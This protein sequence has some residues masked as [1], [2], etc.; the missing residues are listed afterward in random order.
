M[1]KPR[2]TIILLASVILALAVVLIVFRKRESEYQGRSLSEWLTDFEGNTPEVRSSAKFLAAADAIRHIGTSALPYLIE[3]LRYNPDSKTQQALASG[4]DRLPQS[5][6]PSNLDDW[7]SGQTGL[8]NAERAVIAIQILG[9]NALPALPELV[10]IAQD[11]ASEDRAYRVVRALDNIGPQGI[12]ALCQIVSNTN[13][14]SP[15]RHTAALTIGFFGTNSFEAVP[16]L[17]RCLDDP[18]EDVSVGATHALGQIRSVSPASVPAL[19]R[20]L[21]DPSPRK[22]GTAAQSLAHYGPEATPAIPALRQALTNTNL[23][24]QNEARRALLII[25]PEVLTNAPAK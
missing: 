2:K 22:R 15:A 9:T 24:V 3:Q 19:I 17:I 6:V 1:S 12:P 23:Y 18:N 10:R 5:I 25:A 14:P 4:L 20:M 11:P 8:D 16:F 21:Q 7:R 13:A